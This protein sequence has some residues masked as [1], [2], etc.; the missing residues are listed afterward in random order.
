MFALLLAAA[1]TA[2]KTLTQ[3]AAKATQVDPTLWEKIAAA[4]RETWATWGSYAV[5][6]IVCIVLVRVWKSLKEFN[7]FVP[8][9]AL[10]ALGGTVIM[11]WGYERNEPKLL[12]PVF[13]L[14]APYLPSRIEYKDAPATKVQ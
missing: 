5:A 14:L 13:D 2:G 1:D 12:K 7:E 9:V 11:Y 6:I 8:W 4:P 10:F 3:T